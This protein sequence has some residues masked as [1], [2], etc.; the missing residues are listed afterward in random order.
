MVASRRPRCRAAGSP[1]RSCSSTC[2]QRVIAATVEAGLVS[3]PGFCTPTEAFAALG[4]GA[5][6][7]KLF[8]AESA[9]PAVLK[10]LRAVLPPEVPVLPVGGIVPGSMAAWLAAGAAG[11]GLGSA[12]YRKGAS[13]AE[14]RAHAGEFV[15]ALKSAR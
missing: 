13:A 11:F 4:A 12:L 2:P 8:P 5:T 15:A 1:H 10:A 6:G 14:V 7:L 3:L 9:G